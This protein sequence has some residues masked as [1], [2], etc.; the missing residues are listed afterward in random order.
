MLIKDGTVDVFFFFFL[1]FF[2]FVH[3][4]SPSHFLHLITL[5]CI[6]YFGE[7]ESFSDL[8]MLCIVPVTNFI[9]SEHFLP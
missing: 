9:I 1:F 8:A 7:K 6:L 2:V 3:F 5:E 4:R